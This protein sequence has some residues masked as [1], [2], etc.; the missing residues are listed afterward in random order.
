MGPPPIISVLGIED[1]DNDNH[2]DLVISFSPAGRKETN[3]LPI[4]REGKADRGFASF[5]AKRSPAEILHKLSSCHCQI[6]LHLDHAPSPHEKPR[7]VC[8]GSLV[9]PHNTVRLAYGTLT[10]DRFTDDPRNFRFLPPPPLP[11]L[12]EPRAST[13]ASPCLARGVCVA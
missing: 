11:I 3:S 7:G 6:T 8:W 13:R 12:H 5:L 4:E 9:S 2:R 1:A 10:E